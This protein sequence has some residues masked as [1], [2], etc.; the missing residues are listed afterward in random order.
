[1]ASKLAELKAQRRNS[2]DG[3][4]AI[5]MEEIKSAEKPSAGDAEYLKQFE[6]I[7]SSLK[8][9]EKNTAEVYALKSRSDV[10]VKD[11]Q[12]KQIMGELDDLMTQTKGEATKVT[13][14]LNRMEEDCTAYEKANDGSTN[15][16]IR[17]NLLATHTR[18]FQTAMKEYQDASESFR[19]SLKQRI[20]RQARIVKE[21]ITE[22]EVNRIIESDD[23]A[24]FLKEA[25]GLSDVLV[26]AVAELEERHERMRKIEHGVREILE[27]FQELATLVEIQ[28]EHLDHIEQNVAQAKNYT[29]KAEKELIEAKKS[30]SQA[31]KWTFWLLCVLL[32]ILVVVLSIV[33]TT[34]K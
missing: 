18:H 5:Q 7:K 19:E 17:R 9:I 8:K 26:E 32:V 23:P 4:V 13:N 1:M 3:D 10:E 12:Q 16:L 22:E 6:T 2:G 31:R 33:F 28:Q 21:D 24:K 15:A 27:L 14:L 11:S 30:Q 20:A 25:M 29:E 34:K